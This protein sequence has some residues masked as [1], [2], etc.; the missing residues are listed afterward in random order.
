MT[1]R[2]LIPLGL[3]ALG[4]AAPAA[5]QSPIAE[6]VCAPADE[7]RQRLKRDYG[8]TLSGQGV[9]DP[10]S[11]MEIWSSD[12]G[13]WTL[14][15]AYAGGTRCIVAMGEAWDSLPPDPA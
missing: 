3:L 6:V 7:M 13:A 15:I 14:V 4:L 5:A 9:R 2:A 12:R 10:E 11:V 8:A 1:L